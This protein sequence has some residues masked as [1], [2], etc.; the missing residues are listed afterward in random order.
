MGSKSM[1]S[2]LGPKL[3]VRRNARTYASARGAES[4]VPRLR[5]IDEWLSYA[6]TYRTPPTRSSLIRPS[7][8]V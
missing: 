8:L 5:S 4:E 3:R 1:T 2:P 7:T 6:H